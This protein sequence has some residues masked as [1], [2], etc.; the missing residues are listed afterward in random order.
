M[1]DSAQPSQDADITG[2]LAR[3]VT[4]IA[5][6]LET[7]PQAPGVYRMLGAKGEPLY[8]GKAKNLRKRVV[9]YT[10]PDR[11]TLRIQRMIA[12]TVSMEVVTTHTEVEALLLESNLI[13][14]LG[15]RY[16]ILLKD[17]KSFPHI[18]VTADHDFP[19]VLKHR[20]ARGRKGAY[21]GPFA[22]AGA[23]NQT[24][25]ALQ[26]AF[27]L[28]SCSDSVFSNRTRPCL[29]YQI[30][31]CSAPCVDRISRDD[32]LAL[33]EEARAFLS[34]HSQRIQRELAARMEEASAAME[35]E[36]AA[37]F[38]DRIR[39]LSRIQAHQD[40]NPAEV[41]EA[42]VVALHQAG[43]ASCVQV[44]FFRSGC[45]YGTR[46]YFPAHAQ[47]AEAGEVMAAFLG[48][49]YADKTPPREILVSQE[50]AEA[51]I[52][53]RALSEK[54]GRKVAVAVP[55]RGDR[56][57]LMEHAYDNA[58]EALGR[59]LAEGSAQA[60]LLAGLAELFGLDA[61]PE[62]IEV[63]DNSH[64]QGTNAVGAMVVAGPEGWMK[65]SYRK[66]NI[67]SD[68]LTPGDDFAMMREVLTRRFK[69]VARED[70]DRS[71][72]QWPDLVLIDGG[73]GQLSSAL[74]VFAELGIE[75]VPLA[76]IAKG[77]DRNAGRERFFLPGRE[78]FSPEPK[79]PVLYYLQR[80]RDEAHRFAIG[81]HRAR[82]AKAMGGSPLDE[83]AGIGARRKKALLH[84]FGSARE[85][86]AAGLA[87]LEAVAGISH[88]MAKKIYDHF[89]PQG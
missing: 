25:A 83:V 31:R 89:H 20:G 87:D 74:E 69:R 68:E 84:H 40:I 10:R 52:V 79:D 60:K 34:G 66:F 39:A 21:F 49:F 65:Q 8:V 7:M 5:A 81:S 54:A 71:G 44:F 23:V 13:K 82:R 53:A 32:Y 33:V 46:S 11:Q 77:P 12:E 56:K 24:L 63:Y 22:S 28:R 62:R 43:G 3:G 38:R 78:P 64:I 27:L 4:V 75:E 58:R 48:Q 9:A 17:D 55:K 16:N 2:P 29:L 50:P 26:R 19:Q 14:Q 45:N 72:G 86:A 76:A 47:D 18:L 85:V 59:R 80:L 61:P 35:Y 37:V 36:A 73:A 30:K 1:N 42:D 70:P 67:R 88:A 57:R 41:A 6:N 15:P 51:A